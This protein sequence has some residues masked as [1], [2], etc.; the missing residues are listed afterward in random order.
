MKITSLILALIMAL[1]V[2]VGCSEKEEK[3]ADTTT[4]AV[5]EAV[6]VVATASIVDT[7]EAL[8]KAAGPDVFWLFGVLKDLTVDSEIVVEGEFT[9]A[10]KDDATKM[11]PAGRKM[12][13]YSQDA[14]RNKTASYTVTAPKMIVKSETTKIQGGTFKGD[15][16]VEANGFNL[17]D[18]TVDGNVYFASEEFKASFTMDE[19]SKVTGVTEVK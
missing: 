19:K 6:D 7:P 8:L 2:F 17:V 3:V 12:A 1:S 11:V 4:V 14:D 15:V 9:K 18:A 5:T 10:D 16:Y 13:L